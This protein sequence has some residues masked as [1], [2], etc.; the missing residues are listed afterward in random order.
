MTGLTFPCQE[1]RVE[2]GPCNPCSLVYV[3]RVSQ[4]LGPLSPEHSQSLLFATAPLTTATQLT[5][6]HEG[7]A[8][9]AEIL[10]GLLRCRAEGKTTEFFCVCV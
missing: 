10:H 5:Q 4:A 6:L 9:A 7:Q 1:P 8:Q 3:S 2:T